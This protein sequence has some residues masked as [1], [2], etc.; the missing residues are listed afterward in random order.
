MLSR[1]PPS[2]PATPTGLGSFWTSSSLPPPGNNA[3]KKSLSESHEYRAHR[4][5]GRADNA[6]TAFPCPR[7]F[8]HRQMDC[9]RLGRSQ[10]TTTRSVPPL[11]FPTVVLRPGAVLAGLLHP[12]LRRRPGSGMWGSTAKPRTQSIK[13][14]LSQRN[15][16][17]KRA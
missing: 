9:W 15:C 16:K 12:A 1:P 3:R 5:W 8:R 4:R 2:F 11:F 10:I 17:G 6:T 13:A 7:P 14:T